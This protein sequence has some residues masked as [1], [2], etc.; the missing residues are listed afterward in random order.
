VYEKLE[1]ELTRFEV[2]EEEDQMEL[3]KLIDKIQGSAD[4]MQAIEASKHDEIKIA[5]GNIFDE[6]VGPLMVHQNQD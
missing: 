1:K 6:G 4:S 2:E 3:S 5:D